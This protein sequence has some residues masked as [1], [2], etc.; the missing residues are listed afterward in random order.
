MTND[1]FWPDQ[2]SRCVITDTKTNRIIA[3]PFAQYAA[4]NRK[5]QNSIILFPQLQP[6]VF[7]NSEINYNYSDY[8]RT[9]TGY[10]YEVINNELFTRRE[11]TKYQKN[12]LHKQYN[13]VVTLSSKSLGYL[14][15]TKSVQCDQ[16]DQSVLDQVQLFSNHVSTKTVNLTQLRSI[17]TPSHVLIN[18]DCP[19]KLG[20]I[21]VG[22]LSNFQNF[23]QQIRDS[24]HQQMPAAKCALNKLADF[25]FH[26]DQE[27]LIKNITELNI[28]DMSEFM[29]QLK[30][31]IDL[32]GNGRV[33]DAFQLPLIKFILDR[34]FPVTLLDYMNYKNFVKKI[35]GDKLV[36]VEFDEIVPDTVQTVVPALVLDVVFRTGEIS[37]FTALTYNLKQLLNNKD[38]SEIQIGYISD[39]SQEI[40][41]RNIIENFYAQNISDKDITQQPVQIQQMIIKRIEIY[42][43]IIQRYQLHYFSFSNGDNWI[44]IMNEQLKAQ[45]LGLSEK[46][47]IGQINGKL[48]VTKALTINSKT[49]DNQTSINGF[50]TIVLKQDFKFIFEQNYTL[51]DAN[52]RYIA[53]INDQTY[54]QGV[55]Q[56]LLKH[57]YIKEM[58]INYTISKINS[59]YELNYSFWNTALL[60]SQQKEFTLVITQNIQENY[61]KIHENDYNNSD[62]YERAIIFDASCDY[63]ISGKIMVKQFGAIDAILVTFIDVVPTQYK[64]IENDSNYLSIQKI[65]YYNN[66]LNSRS[67]SST[68][69]IYQ[70]FPDKFNFVP[71]IKLS[72]HEIS[73]LIFIFVIPLIILVFIIFTKPSHKRNYSFLAYK[74]EVPMKIDQFKIY[75]INQFANTQCKIQHNQSNVY[76]ILDLFNNNL[77]LLYRSDLRRQQFLRNFEHIQC[78]LEFL[79]APGA[80]S[81]NY[82]SFG[83]LVTSQ[84]YALIR[85]GVLTRKTW[86]PNNHIIIKG[87]MQV[88]YHW[89]TTICQPRVKYHHVDSC[90]SSRSI[91]KN[92]SRLLSRVSSDNDSTFNLS[93]EQKFSVNELIYQKLF[94]DRFVKYTYLP[95]YSLNIDTPSGV[96][97]VKVKAFCLT[98]DMGEIIQ[99]A[100]E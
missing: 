6:I 54:I 87:S 61:N 32:V 83:I 23:K 37:M 5:L 27:I 90:S 8:L 55:K 3:D 81:I 96:K 91:S 44:P 59:I 93:E 86:L 97:I 71:I 45:P 12:Y 26:Y 34:T 47:R 60:K 49:L 77:K 1:V 70:K 52:I 42:L 33:Q 4:Y 22:N 21:C 67:Y 18:P 95:T 15:R 46:Y 24:F 48:S 40:T 72:D 94:D 25:T 65:G 82:L 11:F 17:A 78:V 41:Y 56:V 14:W 57:N 99:M 29:N 68:F 58:L 92:I 98:Q 43:D 31:C 74:T 88:T 19:N 69:Q 85:N 28:G 38:I 64:Q 89:G 50:L 76:K 30:Q 66:N 53:G 7:N 9:T 100:I 2:L 80:D 79:R 84:H 63:F 20:Q 62:I 39:D 36:D 35:V 16:S 51:F 73:V 13:A 75:G 10:V